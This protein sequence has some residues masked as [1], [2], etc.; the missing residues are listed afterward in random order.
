M[1]PKILSH[2]DPVDRRLHE[3]GSMMLLAV[4]VVLTLCLLSM[5]YW[6]LVEINTQM[7]GLKEGGMMAFFAARGGIEEAAYELKQG[8]VWGS[9]T[10]SPQWRLESGN[11]YYKSTSSAVPLTH[12]SYPT[13]MS[14][15]VVGDPETQTVNVTSVAQVS[16]RGQVFSRR[17]QAKLIKSTPEGSI[18]ILEVQEQ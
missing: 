8:H 12:F 6:K 5:S 16:R 14:V 7:A 1:H 9:D 4:F 17:L 13:T 3:A 18:H 11:T 10:M 15:T 2:Q